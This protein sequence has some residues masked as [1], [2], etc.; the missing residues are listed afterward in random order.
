M[1]IYTCLETLRLNIRNLPFKKQYEL[2]TIHMYHDYGDDYARC[3]VRLFN[4]SG[5]M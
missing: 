4:M 1:T 2:Q 5:N 3:C